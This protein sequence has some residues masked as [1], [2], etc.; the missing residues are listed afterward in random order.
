MPLEHIGDGVYILA[1][2]VPVNVTG[3][4]KTISVTVSQS[5]PTE[6]HQV[7][8]P[9]TVTVLPQTRPMDLPIF[10]EKLA[11]NWRVINKTWKGYLSRSLAEKE[12]I[13]S[14]ERAA[15]FHVTDGDWDWV[16]GFKPQQPLDLAGYDRLRVALN[17]SDLIPPKQSRST[18]S[19]YVGNKLLDLLATGFINMQQEGWQELDVPLAYF[20][21]STPIQ[22]ISFSGNFGGLFYLDELHL[23]T[24]PPNTAVVDAPGQTP[25]V[26]T[27]QQNYPNPFNSTTVI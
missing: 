19:L 14:G 5:A 15:A 25:S 21:V 16:V 23:S 2:D 13:Y 8:L 22:E 27:R 4:S 18:F 6:S 9:Q 17:F 26:L 7:R 12:A 20:E 10:S 11:T 3:G 24:D 1:V